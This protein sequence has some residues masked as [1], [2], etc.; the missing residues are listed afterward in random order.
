MTHL[1][2]VHSIRRLD[3]TFQKYVYTYFERPICCCGQCGKKTSLHCRRAE[4]NLFAADCPNIQ[5]FRNVSCSE[6]YL[7]RGAAVDETITCISDRQ[8]SI[9]TKSVTSKHLEKL[10]KLNSGDNNPSSI[11]SIIIRTGKCEAEVRAELSQKTSGKNNGFAGRKHRPEVL[12][13]LAEVRAQQSK[14]I[15]SPE[16]IIWGMLHAL[17]IKFEYQVAVDK[18]VVDFRI[19]RILL[20]VYG[21][22]WHGEKMSPSHKRHDKVK[23]N[24]LS[25]V[26]DLIIIQE[27]QIVN[28]PQSVVKRLCELKE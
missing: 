9:A 3:D 6:Y 23:E 15:S 17:G 21:D 14:Q 12:R 19:G 25:S 26:Y 8:R 28:S 1:H 16:L 10:A 24:Y 27:S 5:R 4:F 2:D 13:R 7:F 20:E 22:Y 11:K 18:Y